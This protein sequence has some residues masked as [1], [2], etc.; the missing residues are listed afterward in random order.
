MVSSKKVRAICGRGLH[1]G[2]E[3]RV[4]R[5]GPVYTHALTVC[6]LYLRVCM[7]H[8]LTMPQVEFVQL[9][10]DCSLSFP[11]V[12]KG[13]S[14][15]H[16]TAPTTAPAT[17]PATAL[18]L[19]LDPASTPTLALALTLSL[20]PTPAPTPAPAAT[21]APT[22]APALS[23]RVI[24]WFNTCLPLWRRVRQL[25]TEGFGLHHIQVSN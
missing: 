10:N 7:Y 6:L 2:N 4:S 11:L 1:H 5:L 25:E 14:D 20:A 16:A 17:A 15:K 21:P 22:P 3:T 24:R 23:R 8:A 12:D 13:S 9:S 19:A 18:A